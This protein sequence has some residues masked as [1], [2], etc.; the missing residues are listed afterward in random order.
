MWFLSCLF[1]E[2]LFPQAQSAFLMLFSRHDSQILMCKQ[3]TGRSSS[4]A[5]VIPVSVGP[6]I[7]LF[8][9]VPGWTKCY[10]SKDHTLSSKTGDFFPLSSSSLYILITTKSICILGLF[11]KY[12]S[13]AY[14]ASQIGRLSASPIQNG[15]HYPCTAK[16]KFL[17]CSMCMSESNIIYSYSNCQTQILILHSAFLVF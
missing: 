12:H 9:Q 10:G 6:K 2:F 16:Q 5:V 15:S 14:L 7:L 13:S 4:T 17:P 1:L 8:C 11:C 3:V